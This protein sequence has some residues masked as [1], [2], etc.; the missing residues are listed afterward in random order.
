MFHTAAGEA[1]PVT[2]KELR[3]QTCRDP[4]LSCV[5][6]L[7]QMGLQ[8]AEAHTELIPFAHSKSELRTH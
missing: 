3:K 6:E 1:L 5:L 8:E 7:V 2:E 4:I